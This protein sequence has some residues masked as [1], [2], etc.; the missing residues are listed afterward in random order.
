MNDRNG[1]LTKLIKMLPDSTVKIFI[2]SITILIILFTFA[3]LNTDIKTLYIQDL[4]STF[5]TAE[6]DSHIHHL[7]ERE[8]MLLMRVEELEASLEDVKQSRSECSAE[9]KLLELR[10]S[11]GFVATMDSRTEAG[12]K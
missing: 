7:L 3:I 4:D 1:F 2:T 10:C 8:D 12:V 9:L 5:R 11:G 6:L